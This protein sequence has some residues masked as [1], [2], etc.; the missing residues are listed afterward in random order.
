ML[1][2]LENLSKTFKTKSKEIKVFQNIN[3]EIKDREMLVIFGPSGIGKT[4]L[5]N[6]IGG[7]D[8]PTSGK[9]IINGVDLYTLK[10]DE[11]AEFR[12]EKIGFIFQTF[13]LLPNLKAKDNIALPALLDKDLDKKMLGIYEFA[14]Q[15][16]MKERLDHKPQELSSGEQQRVAILRAMINSPSIILADEPT[17]DLDDIN[18]NKIIEI[19]KG[20]NQKYGSTLVIATNDERTAMNFPQRYVLKT[21]S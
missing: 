18:A 7:M 9:V 13:N 10:S 4:T 21:W 12:K 6:L 16:G 20:L 5:L 19:L 11:L 15:I 14:S 2:K 3:M 8:N 1:I 17:A